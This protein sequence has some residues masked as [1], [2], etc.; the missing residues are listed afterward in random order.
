MCVSKVELRNYLKWVGVNG[1]VRNGPPRKK[2]SPRYI[3]VE[4][5][6]IPGECDQHGIVSAQVDN[7]TGI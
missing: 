5:C 4:F 2:G 1:G 6:G 7:G 3:G